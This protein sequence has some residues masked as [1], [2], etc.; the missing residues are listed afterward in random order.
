M[1]LLG[2]GLGT[3]FQ[4]FPSKCSIKVRLTYCGPLGSCDQPTAQT[5]FSDIA[6]TPRSSLSVVAPLTFGLMVFCQ[7]PETG[8]TVFG[9]LGNVSKLPIAVLHPFLVQL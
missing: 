1:S 8:G 4:L 7:E 5:L 3:M 2:F 9:Q 6:A